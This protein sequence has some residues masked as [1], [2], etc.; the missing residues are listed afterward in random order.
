MIFY[1]KIKK[2]SNLNFFIILNSI[3]FQ[4]IQSAVFYQ[5]NTYKKLKPNFLMFLDHMV[6]CDQ[7]KLKKLTIERW[8]QKVGRIDS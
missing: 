2:K 6:S 4:A 7:N 8:P 3:Y 5:I 1:Y